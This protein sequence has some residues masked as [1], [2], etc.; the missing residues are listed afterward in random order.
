M[1]RRPLGLA[2]YAAAPA[3]VKLALDGSNDT[4]AGLL[5]LIALVA[6]ETRPVAGAVVLAAAAAFKPYALAWLPGLVGWAGLPALGAFAAASAL[7]WSPLLAWGPG[8]YLQ[9]LRDAEAV[10]HR[11]YASLAAAFEWLGRGSV[12][13][14]VFLFTAYASGGLAAVATF[15]RVRSHDAL[16]IGGTLVFA[17]TLYLGYWATFAYVSAVAPILCWKLDAWA[18]RARVSSPR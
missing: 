10:H 12:P 13:R 15:F 6:A 16:V 14:Q 17:A 3:V 4:S 7:F 1:T 8:A 18:R 2:V 11:P 5:I 9:S